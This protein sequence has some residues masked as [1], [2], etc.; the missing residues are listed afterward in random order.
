MAESLL[1]ASEKP[2]Y[3]LE[4]PQ[5]ASDILLVCE[6]ASRTLPAA[7]DGLGLSAQTQLS[8]AAWDIGALALSQRL[9]ERLD[10]PLIHQRYSRL[11]YDCNRPPDA[12]D[13]M[14]A[15]SEIH[16]IPGN[17]NLTAAEKTARVTDIYLPFSQGIGEF[18]DQRLAA[19]R[20]PWL[21]TIHS[22]TPIYH[23]RRRDK[24]LGVLFGTDARLGQALLRAAAG[25]AGTS[26]AANYPYSAR[27]GVLHTLERH[28]KPR[29]LL[30]VMLEIRNDLLRTAE[31]QDL[32][33]D[34]LSA[35]FG[36]LGRRL[37]S[38]ARDRRDRGGGDDRGGGNDRGGGGD[39]GAAENSPATAPLHLASRQ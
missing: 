12:P 24:E 11:V 37:D 18:L 20:R 32:W 9:S 23:G 16:Q 7:L 10:A 22:F 8:H 15:R 27:D 35:L 19:G 1:S 17:L 30:N 33:A 28:A 4:R 2:C 6:H 21:V 25:M 13:A 38:Q 29:G 26:Y 34:R 39:R 31:G 14:P 36:Q 3:L 5:G